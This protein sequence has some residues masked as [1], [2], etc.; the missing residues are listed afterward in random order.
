MNKCKWYVRVGLIQS[1]DSINYSTERSVLS[2][3]EIT[4][5][6]YLRATLFDIHSHESQ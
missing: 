4:S 6:A 5:M 3:N 1:I 2:T